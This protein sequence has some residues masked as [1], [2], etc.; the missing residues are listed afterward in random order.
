M[1][2]APRLICDSA[3]LTDSGRGVRF[4]IERHGEPVPA[5]AVRYRGRVHA[6]LNRCSHVPMELDWIEGQFFDLQGRDL[7]C[8]THGAEYDTASG[9]C[10]G[11][12]C[13]GA[14]L[15]NLEVEE[16]GGKVYYL[17]FKDGR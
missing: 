6:Y 7:I 3:A 10:L 1:A 9:R 8:S 13:S 12:P 17:G 14:P 2:D 11:G 4:E 5:F 15:V 16:R